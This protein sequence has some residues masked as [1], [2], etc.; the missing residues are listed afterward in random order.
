MKGSACAARGPWQTARRHTAP[1]GC[2]CEGRVT[3]LR[4]AAMRCSSRFVR[5]AVGTLEPVG[6]ARNKALLRSFRFDR[7]GRTAQISRADYR[8][9]REVVKAEYQAEIS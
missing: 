6:R 5:N 1:T 2:D 7:P 8:E 4:R 3:L 9:S